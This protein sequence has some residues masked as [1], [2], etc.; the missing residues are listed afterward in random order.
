MAEQPPFT[1]EQFYK[2]VL[3]GKLMA[4]KCKKCG[5][6]HLPP[7]PLCDNCYSRDFEWVEIPGKGKLLTYTIIHVAPAQFQ[8][9]APYAVGIVQLGNGL[10]IPGMISGAA[11]DQI[12]IGM[13]LVIDF[14]TCSTTQQWPQWPRY[15]FKPA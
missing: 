7:R 13:D 12:Q 1:I 10:K 9:M 15:C 8:S 3:Q 14:G 11:L 2:Y 5:K 6:V 4:G